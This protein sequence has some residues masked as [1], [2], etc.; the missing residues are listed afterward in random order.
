MSS[1][2][3]PITSNVTLL[4]AAPRTNFDIEH[5]PSLVRLQGS[6]RQLDWCHHNISTYLFL[7]FLSTRLSVAHNVGVTCCSLLCGC[8]CPSSHA[9]ACTYPSLFVT[10]TG[11]L[12]CHSCDVGMVAQVAY[13]NLVRGLRCLSEPGHHNTTQKNPSK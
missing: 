5:M 11:V 1:T 9:G 4:S 2:V 12:P 10:T 7:P 6:W 13:G 3:T 8:L